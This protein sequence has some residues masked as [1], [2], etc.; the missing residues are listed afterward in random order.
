MNVSGLVDIVQSPAYSTGL[1]LVRYGIKHSQ[2]T[3]REGR[4]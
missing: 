1:G 2:G 4:K 3:L